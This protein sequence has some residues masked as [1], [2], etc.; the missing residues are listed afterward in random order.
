VQAQCARLAAISE[1][2]VAT[3]LTTRRIT[4]Y[5][6]G[7]PSVYGVTLLGRESGAR[8]VQDGSYTD[9]QATGRHPWPWPEPPEMLCL[10]LGYWS[11]ERYGR[12]ML[13]HAETWKH[14]LN[15]ALA[16]AY[17]S[18]DRAEFVRLALRRLRTH[19]YAVPLQLVGEADPDM[20][21]LCG[22]DWSEYHWVREI[23]A[24]L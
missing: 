11:V 1:R 23:A 14:P 21:M 17:S 4:M 5:H 16:A 19:E 18:Q 6:Q 10:E 3:S 9:Y 12:H 2:K 15:A 24:E 20:Q 8:F 22:T 13:Q 7:P